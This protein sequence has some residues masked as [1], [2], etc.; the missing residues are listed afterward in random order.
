MKSGGSAAGVC[1]SSL[2]GRKGTNISAGMRRSIT[3]CAAVLTTRAFSKDTD[4]RNV[5]SFEVSSRTDKSSGNSAVAMVQKSTHA[6]R[7]KRNTCRVE[8]LASITEFLR[9]QL[10]VVHALRTRRKVFFS[11]LGQA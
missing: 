10:P 8:R 7:E 1:S 6:M 2:T 5:K 9:L 4:S 11:A 3:N